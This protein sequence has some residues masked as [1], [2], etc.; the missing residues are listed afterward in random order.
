MDEQTKKYIDKVNEAYEKI[1]VEEIS[2]V[3]IID[4]AIKK[5]KSKSDASTGR[6]K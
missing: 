6:K 3:S 5:K 1:I 2:E 4:K